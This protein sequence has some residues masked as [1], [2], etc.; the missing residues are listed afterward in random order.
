MGK[1]KTS[2]FLAG[3]LG[4]MDGKFSGLSTFKKNIC[5][6]VGWAKRSVPI[7]SVSTRGIDGHGLLAFAHPTSSAFASGCGIYPALVAYQLLKRI[8]AGL[9]EAVRG[10][11][12]RWAMFDLPER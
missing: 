5:R 3:I 4:D 9:E 2:L 12:P 8:F 10:F 6:L 11:F 1:L 7:I